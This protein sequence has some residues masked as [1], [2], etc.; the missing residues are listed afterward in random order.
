MLIVSH[1]TRFATKNSAK[2]T[3]IMIRPVVQ[4]LIAPNDRAIKNIMGPKAKTAE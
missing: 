4:R 1:Y 2:I 3:K